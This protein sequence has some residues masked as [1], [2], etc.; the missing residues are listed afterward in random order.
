M[1][2]KVTSKEQKI[3]NNYVS[4]SL[5]ILLPLH[6]FI[7]IYLSYL[8]FLSIEDGNI[9]IEIEISWVKLNIIISE[10]VCRRII[11]RNAFFQFANYYYKMIMNKHKYIYIMLPLLISLFQLYIPFTCE[12]LSFLKI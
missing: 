12:L 7:S 10:V 3:R 8:C 1:T 4:S 11:R 5:H 9:E 6:P 2:L